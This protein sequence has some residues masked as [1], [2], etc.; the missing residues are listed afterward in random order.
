MKTRLVDIKAVAIVKNPSKMGQCRM[1][2]DA[3]RQ[4]D[5]RLE[6]P[7]KLGLHTDDMLFDKKRKSLREQMKI[8]RN[9]IFVT[10]IVTNN[11]RRHT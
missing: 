4:R 1:E 3:K 7:L 10:E 8:P 2:M 9:K 6:L 11:K 5:M